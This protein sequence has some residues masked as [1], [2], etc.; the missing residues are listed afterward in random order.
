MTD[1]AI[2]YM[3]ALLMA[4]P[5]VIVALTIILTAIWERHHP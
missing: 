3:A 4:L 1:Q 5:F 2:A